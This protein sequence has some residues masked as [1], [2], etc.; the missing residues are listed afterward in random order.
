MTA[1]V[2]VKVTQ[3]RIGAMAIIEPENGEQCQQR[4]DAKSKRALGGNATAYFL[5]QW[6]ETKPDG[7]GHW[8]LWSKVNG[9]VGW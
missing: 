4:L 9:R 6:V 8:K 2:I 5:A 7:R 1:R 3:P